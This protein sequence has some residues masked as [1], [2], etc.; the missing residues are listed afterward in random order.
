MTQLQ[1]HISLGSPTAQGTHPLDIQITASVVERRHG[2][3]YVF[4]VSELNENISKTPAC[5][6]SLEPIGAPFTHGRLLGQ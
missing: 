4:P 5:M 3:V 6:K 2:N 1:L